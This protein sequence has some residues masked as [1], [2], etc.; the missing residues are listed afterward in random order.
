MQISNK[1]CYALRAL[2]ELSR[3]YSDQ[4]PI[5]I[6]TVASAQSIPKRFLEVILN[7]L[8]QGGFVESRRGVDGGYLL[9]REPEDI[10]VGE[11]IRFVD[12]NLAPVNCDSTANGETSSELNYNHPYYDFWLRVSVRMDEIYH[13]TSLSDIIGD[14]DRRNAERNL[15]YDI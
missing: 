6:A 4:R 12:G 1:C 13:G 11:I 9:A 3:R 14:W 10:S 8:R 15:S 7:E 5:K 2:F